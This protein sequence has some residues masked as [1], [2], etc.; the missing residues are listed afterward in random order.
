MF[1]WWI[2]KNRRINQISNRTCWVSFHGTVIVTE[3]PFVTA[4]TRLE[5]LCLSWVSGL[6]GGKG[7]GE[8]FGLPFFALF[9]PC[10]PRIAWFSEYLMPCTA[11]KGQIIMIIWLAL[12]FI[13][14]QATS[15]CV[16]KTSTCA[17][18]ERFIWCWTFTTKFSKLFW[19]GWSCVQY[20]CKF[21]SLIEIW[22]LLSMWS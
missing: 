8:E 22:Q 12:F 11:L 15:D 13:E 5:A 18:Q 2:D 7:E 19:R 20:H 17:E 14:I 6:P 10:F 4:L 3:T 1:Y 16:G 21:E 9:S